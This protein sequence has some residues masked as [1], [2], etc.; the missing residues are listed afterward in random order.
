MRW[1]RVA[2]VAGSVPWLLAASCGSSGSAKSPDGGPLD[3]AS[4]V[5]ETVQVGGNIIEI[6]GG[7][8]I[9][10][11]QICI[12]GR[13]EIPCATSGPDGS[14]T[15][16]IPAW[17]TDVDIAFNVKAA[18][19]LGTTGLVHET[20]RGVTWLSEPMY[21]DAAAAD[22]MNHAGFAYPAGGKSFV[23]VS[24]WSG[25]GGAL[26]GATVSSSPAAGEGPAYAD[27]IGDPDPTLTGITSNG[28]ALIGGLTP[29][30]VEIT[31][32]DPSCHPVDIATQAWVDTKPNTIAGT[33]VADS[34]THM[35]VICGP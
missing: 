30:P 12:V 13:P 29:G 9:A 10:G 21:D 1:S 11:A 2:V 28:Y 19:H 32:S 31:V 33:T 20:T 3:G 27:P 17:T 15:L 7:G 22:L 26:Q 5:A 25:S 4:S 18:G 8:P 24:V 34:M 6:K 14:Y 16:S 35:I 23:L